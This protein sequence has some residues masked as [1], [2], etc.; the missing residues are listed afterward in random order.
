MVSEA[1]RI[2]RAD[3][4]AGGYRVGV[5]RA[6]GHRGVRRDVRRV[7]DGGSRASLRLCARECDRGPD[8]RLSLRAWPGDAD[9]D[10]GRHR[11]RRRSLVCWSATPRRSRSWRR[12]TTLVVDKTGT[13]TEGKPTL[14]A[15]ET[16]PGG[17]ERALLRLAASLEHVSE[18]PLAA[19]IVAGARDRGVELSPVGSFES[20]T[21]RGV[22]GL[23]E[24]RTVAIGN[25]AHFAARR[26]RPGRARAAGRRAAPERAD[27]DVRRDR[28]TGR[29]PRGRGGSR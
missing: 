25:V 28:R 27:R 29:R 1:Q 24:G 20:L 19:A 8:H 15:V 22:I 3:S 2:A 4:A 13:L 23:V 17:D 7:G 18:H 6:G 11:T 10:H 9:V 16:V 21:G 26:Y 12:S 5:V 14:V